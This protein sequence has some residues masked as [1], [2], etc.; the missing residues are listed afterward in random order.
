[1]VADR[2]A[3]PAGRE[4]AENQTNGFCIACGVRAV[5]KADL[6]SVM[7]QQLIQI[8]D[9]IALRL[10]KMV[11]AA[12]LPR[13][14]NP[15]NEKA[16][17]HVTVRK[18]GD[19]LDHKVSHVGQGRWCQSAGW[20]RFASFLPVEMLALETVVRGLCDIGPERPWVIIDLTWRRS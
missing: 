14:R 11:D 17:L 16:A 18:C 13:G 6:S 12:H 5:I 9:V 7:E 4:A 8:R 15:Q 10:G 20:L 19:R 1:M 3:N 2:L